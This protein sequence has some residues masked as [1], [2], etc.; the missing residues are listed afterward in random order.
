MKK[1]SIEYNNKSN[2]DEPVNSFHENKIL[3]ERI[4]NLTLMVENL[5]QKL[6]TKQTHGICNA[7]KNKTANTSK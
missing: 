1:V 6:D 3:H 7:N 4:T 2:T 5:T